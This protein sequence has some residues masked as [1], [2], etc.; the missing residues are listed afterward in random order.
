[1]FDFPWNRKNE[2]LEWQNSEGTNL[3]SRRSEPL[4]RARFVTGMYCS[5]K[6]Y[7]SLR[8][9]I[10]LTLLYRV[11]FR[12]MIP[13][14]N[15]GFARFTRFERWTSRPRVRGSWWRG[16]IAR[17]NRY[18]L[19]VAWHSA[20]PIAVFF[21][22]FWQLRPICKPH[23]QMW[24]DVRAHTHNQIA[25]SRCISRKFREKRNCETRYSTLIVGD[26]KNVMP[27]YISCIA[28]LN[29]TIRLYILTFFKEKNNQKAK[30]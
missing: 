4:R 27:N 20:Q 16:A 19:Y 17:T 2:R 11:R 25:I 30:R 6:L 18:H 8:E 15:V 14:E 28:N 9:K 24:R 12:A 3:T 1:M 13:P 22:F 23:T 7:R 5:H 29:P 26:R 21:S 10:S